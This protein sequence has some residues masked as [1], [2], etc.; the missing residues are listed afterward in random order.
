MNDSTET[1][2]RQLVAEIN[3]EPGSRDYLEAKYGEVHNTSELTKAFEPLGFMA[4]FVVV[5]RRCDG[6]K[7]SLQFQH[8]P[9]FYYNFQEDR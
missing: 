4:P 1:T 2:R 9:R 8:S 5:R 7:G 3:L 6:V